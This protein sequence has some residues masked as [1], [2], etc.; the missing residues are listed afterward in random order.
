VT[1]EL[2]RQF[3]S[4]WL[5]GVA[6]VTAA[7]ADG[8][9]CGMT[10]SAVTSL[11]LDPPQFLVC[12]ERKAKTLAAIS[13]S[14]AFCIHILSEDQRELSAHF[15]RPGGDRFTGIPHRINNDGVPVL[16][17]VI[18]R[19]ECRLA[20]ILDGGDHAIV[21]GD[22]QAGEVPGGQPLAHFHRG[23]HKLAS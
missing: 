2:F 10:M 9:L 20:S 23:Y 22:A 12:M 4:H 13:H 21:I 14:K 5:T 15:A 8:E 11:S 7:A 16:D 6:I 18:A 17:G 3:A 1:S 19:L